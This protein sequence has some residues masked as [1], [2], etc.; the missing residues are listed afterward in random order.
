MCFFN[1]RKTFQTTYPLAVGPL[2][3]LITVEKYKTHNMHCL[4]NCRT[5]LCT[6]Y[7]LLLLAAFRLYHLFFVYFY[8][9]V[10]APYNNPP[11]SNTGKSIL[12]CCWIFVTQIVLLLAPLHYTTPILWIPFPISKYI[13]QCL[14]VTIK[15]HQI[16]THSLFL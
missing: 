13:R 12:V 6:Y 15:T 9:S 8:A 3:K 16:D 5:L 14:L 11:I 10:A 4:E 1:G 7:Q 2:Y